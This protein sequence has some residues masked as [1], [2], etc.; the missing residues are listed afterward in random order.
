MP[1]FGITELIIALSIG[2]WF[3]SVPAYVGALALIATMLLLFVPEYFAQLASATWCLAAIFLLLRGDY[4]VGALYGLSWLMYLLLYSGMKGTTY[5]VIIHY[6]SDT[7][8]MLGLLLDI[9]VQ[10]VAGF[11]GGGRSFIPAFNHREMAGS[12]KRYTQIYRREE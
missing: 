4:G 5:E 2:W 10:G 11:R 9:R 3:R 7:F 12:E 8:F 1:I 6:A